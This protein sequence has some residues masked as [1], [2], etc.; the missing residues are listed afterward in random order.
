MFTFALAAFDNPLTFTTLTAF[1]EAVLDAV[2][3]FLFPI[4]V[5]MIVYT[6]FLFVSAQGNPEKL[7]QARRSLLWTVIGG[8]I[9]LGAKAIAMM[10]E[11]TIGAF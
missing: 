9:V 8:L 6:G 10:V 4:V 3:L 11:S 7:N 2:I 5:L 1:L